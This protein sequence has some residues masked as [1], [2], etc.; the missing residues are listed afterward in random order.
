M[1]GLTDKVLASTQ[2]AEPAPTMI[3]SQVLF[4][5]LRGLIIPEL[6]QEQRSDEQQ[7]SGKHETTPCRACCVHQPASYY[8]AEKTTRITNH[9]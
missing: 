1:A 7:H 6:D 8:R 9:E 4:K 5:V 3:K 2:P